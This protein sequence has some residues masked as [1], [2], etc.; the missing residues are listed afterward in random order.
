VRAEADYP[1]AG[2]AD[3]QMLKDAFLETADHE[4]LLDTTIDTTEIDTTEGSFRF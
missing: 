1:N 4:T 3:H 2:G